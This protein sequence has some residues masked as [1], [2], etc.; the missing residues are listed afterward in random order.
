MQNFSCLSKWCKDIYC[1]IQYFISA[2]LKLFG[3]R[4]SLFFKNSWEPQRAFVCGYNW[5][6]SP[7]WK[8]ELKKMFKYLLI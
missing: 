2:I 6:Y 3:L 4:T 7:Y 5:Q 1:F 8:L